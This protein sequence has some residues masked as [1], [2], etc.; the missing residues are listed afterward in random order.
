PHDLHS[1]PTR[2]SSDLEKALNGSQL[3]SSTTTTTNGTDAPSMQL[4]PNT[5]ES[6]G[7]YHKESGDLKLSDPFYTSNH[8]IVLNKFNLTSMRSEEHTSELQSRENL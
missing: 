1:F 5:K 8:S 4:V 3:Y 6:S 2:R 7:S